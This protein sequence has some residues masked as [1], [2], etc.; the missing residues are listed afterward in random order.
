MNVV[1]I[2]ALC[3]ALGFAGV[4]A[5]FIARKVMGAVGVTVMMV[6]VFGIIG[7]CIRSRSWIVLAG[8]NM[9]LCVMVALCLMMELSIPES[10][11]SRKRRK[12]SDDD[13]GD[14]YISTAATM[15]VR[16]IVNEYTKNQAEAERVYTDRPMNVIGRVTK[17]TNGEKHSHVELE[18][19]FMCVCPHGSVR[20]LSTGVRVSITGTLRGKYLLD[21][22]LMVKYPV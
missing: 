15:T 21:D 4:S 11:P 17:I 6:M 12:K 19:V 7:V 1:I 10:K 14:E 3:A 13:E 20:S 16:E 18:G 2:L 5:Y 9:L 8:L 22:C